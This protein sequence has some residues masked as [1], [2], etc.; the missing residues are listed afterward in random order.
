MPSA[1]NSSVR[2]KICLPYRLGISSVMFA[3]DPQIPQD[4]FC[5][6]PYVFRTSNVESPRLT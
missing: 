1:F 3:I 2:I 4:C 6:L 5:P